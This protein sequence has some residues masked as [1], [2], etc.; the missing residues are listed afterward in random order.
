MEDNSVCQKVRGWNFVQR[1][2]LVAPNCYSRAMMSMRP[3][4]I[5][6]PFITL[7]K[8]EG[9]ANHH[10]LLLLPLPFV[11]ILIVIWV[12]SCPCCRRN[13]SYIY[14]SLSYK[15]DSNKLGPS[16]CVCVYDEFA[17]VARPQIMVSLRESGETWRIYEYLAHKSQVCVCYTP[18]TALSSVINIFHCNKR[19]L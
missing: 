6:I 7:I 18:T 4:P 1:R 12:S 11:R 9:K 19:L 17:F 10:H 3:H 15:W 8:E 5:T 14:L 13:K 16:W 2:A